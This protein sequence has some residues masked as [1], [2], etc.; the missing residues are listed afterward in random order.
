MKLTWITDLIRINK[1]NKTKCLPKNQRK[2]DPQLKTRYKHTKRI[3]QS[4]H[5]L[6][7][8]ALCT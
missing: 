5:A 8:S 4:E 2:H 6:D 3:L 7:T 1:N